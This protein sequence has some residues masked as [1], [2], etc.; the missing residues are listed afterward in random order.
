MVEVANPALFGDQA[1]I[2]FRVGQRQLVCLTRALL[3]AP[4]ILGL[5]E[6]TSQ[7]DGDTDRP[8]QATLRDTFIQC[9]VI[10]IAHR[11][12]TVLDY[13]IL[14]MADGAVLEHGPVKTLLCDISSAFHTMAKNA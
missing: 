2:G 9:T 14:V 13:K 8:T 3:P 4:K 1:T 10:A 7:I 5:D 11:I 6:A 12:H